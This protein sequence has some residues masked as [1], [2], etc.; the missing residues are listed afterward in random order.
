VSAK[1]QPAPK[2][3]FAVSSTVYT[4]RLH[5]V[6]WRQIQLSPLFKAQTSHKLLYVP[7]ILTGFI[8]F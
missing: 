4:V 8:K 2:I 6:D 3:T 5:I 7:G 1:Y